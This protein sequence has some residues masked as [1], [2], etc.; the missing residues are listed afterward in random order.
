MSIF[1]SLRVAALAAGT[2]AVFAGDVVVDTIAGSNLIS[3]SAEAQGRGGRGGGM[4]GMREIREL[5]E[6]DF[7]RRDMPLFVE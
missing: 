5:L 4:S 1:R 3:T 6:P 2:A 7:S